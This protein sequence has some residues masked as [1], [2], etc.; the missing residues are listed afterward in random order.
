MAPIPGS[1]ASREVKSAGEKKAKQTTQTKRYGKVVLD[2]I[3]RVQ[4]MV[5]NSAI[6]VTGM[7]GSLVRNIPGTN[8]YDTSALIDTIRANIGFDRLQQ[9]RLASPT[10]GSLGQITERELN[11]LQSSL[12]NLDQ[13]Q[14]EDQLLRNLR[15]LEDIYTGIMRKA[16]AYPDAQE[17]GF[18]AQ[19]EAAAPDQSAP[20]G[21]GETMAIEGRT[22]RKVDGEW[23]EVAP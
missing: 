14:S 4:D 23:F 13:A 10:G 11:F 20:A 8:A 1:A 5:K 6:P 19:Q 12:S 7:A 9:M 2:S 22:F 21:G 17:F 15:D 16:S 18:G 3:D